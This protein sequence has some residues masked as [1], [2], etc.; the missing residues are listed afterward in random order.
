MYIVQ[1]HDVHRAFTTRA[2][3]SNPGK[4]TSGFCNHFWASEFRSGVHQ[5]QELI[6]LFIVK[7][8]ILFCCINFRAR[9]NFVGTRNNVYKHLLMAEILYTF[10]TPLWRKSQNI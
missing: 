5:E 1:A 4:K 10:N 9:A 3:P 8:N 6:S 2:M 7:T